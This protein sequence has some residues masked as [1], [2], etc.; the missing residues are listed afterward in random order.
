LEFGEEDEEFVLSY[1]GD[2]G[3]SPLRD[4]GGSVS[5][6]TPS[7]G[8]DVDTGERKNNDNMWPSW[9]TDI[10]KG[11]DV[12]EQFQEISV[13]GFMDEEQGLTKRRSRSPVR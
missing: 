6:S 12:G 10:L 5:A 4:D 7:S 8:V 13:V 3:T 9:D 11:E 1:G 2:S